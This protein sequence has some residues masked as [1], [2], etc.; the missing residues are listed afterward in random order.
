MFA[1]KKGNSRGGWLP[2]NDDVSNLDVSGSEKY[3]TDEI[4]D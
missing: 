3:Y 1:K 2:L 4:N